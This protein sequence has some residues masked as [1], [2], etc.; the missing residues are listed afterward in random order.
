MTDRLMRVNTEV[1]GGDI[2][3]GSKNILSPVSLAQVAKSQPEGD[4][5]TCVPHKKVEKY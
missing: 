3:S 2:C 1:A 4:E 5:V